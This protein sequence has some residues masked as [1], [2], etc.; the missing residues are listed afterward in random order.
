MIETHI[1]WEVLENDLLVELL[2]MVK[3]YIPWP[4]NY[5]VA[6]QLYAEFMGWA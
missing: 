1:N 3:T 6:S 5:Y 4:N 2:G